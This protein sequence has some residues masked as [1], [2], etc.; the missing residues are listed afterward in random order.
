MF[1]KSTFG[2]YEQYT[3][4]SKDI[5]LSVI[6]L[7]GAL[8]ALRYKG[9]DVILAFDNENDYEKGYCYLNF[10]VGRYANRIKNGRFSLEGN[11]YQLDTNEG[12]NQLHGGKDGFHT[13]IWTLL[14][15]GENWFSLGY[16]S[17]HGEGGYPGTLQATV[18]FS[19]TDHA[20][21]VR[22]QAV[23]DRDTIFAPTLHTYFSLNENC[24]DTRLL[25]NASTY[26]PTDHELIPLEK[27]SVDETFDFRTLRPIKE[28]FDHC[29]IAD[30]EAS[31]LMVGKETAIFFRSNFPAMQLYTGIDLSPVFKKNAGF[32]L[33]CEYCPDSPNRGEFLS[34]LLKVGEEFDRYL[35]YSFCSVEDILL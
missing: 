35:E 23:S 7:G 8:T 27:R 31:A 13:K 12:A 2:P 26:L 5:E 18:T 32:A 11:E 30:G 9:K 20:M 19:L 10:L 15:S 16:T 4:R 25:M 29:F 22:F 1:E 33:E 14:D 34:P 17:P 6:G 24:L 3:L 28:D 21:K